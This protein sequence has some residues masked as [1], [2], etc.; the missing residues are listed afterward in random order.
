MDNNPIGRLED[1]A[2]PI[3]KEYQHRY[4][5]PDAHILFVDDNEM[6]RKVFAGLLKEIKVQIDEAGNGRECLEK[7]KK[8]AY[9]IIFMDHMMPEL[10]G[11]ET[12]RIM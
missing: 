12:V 6:N 3:S 2:E 8:N 4:E 1:L 9:D 5:A 11:V 7:V 10:V